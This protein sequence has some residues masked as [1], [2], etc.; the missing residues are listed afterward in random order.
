MYAGRLQRRE[1][2]I[3]VSSI[4]FLYT[5][6][7]VIDYAFPYDY[8]GVRILETAPTIMYP[9]I[10]VIYVPFSPGVWAAMLG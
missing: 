10:S 2:D 5:R 6:N 4:T 9:G 7:M 8:D 1:L 3:V